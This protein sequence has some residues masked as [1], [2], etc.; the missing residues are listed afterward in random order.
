ML[1]FL[2]SKVTL[3]R[4]LKPA[5]WESQLC[6][7]R[8]YCFPSSVPWTW[9]RACWQQQV[10]RWPHR[11]ADESHPVLLVCCQTKNGDRQAA[12][13]P[14]TG[15][16]EARLC[17]WA[18]WWSPEREKPSTGTVYSA[19]NYSTGP[20]RQRGDTLTCLITE[21]SRSLR[22]PLLLF[23]FLQSPWLWPDLFLLH[24]VW[25]ILFSSS[26]AF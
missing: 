3:T 1:S 7:H 15:G 16:W 25:K 6:P 17:G 26:S 10:R 11:Q 12:R 9:T 2:F 22:P 18:Q 4:S 5:V 8:G 21:I 13:R 19:L 24:S 14:P 20:I 23:L